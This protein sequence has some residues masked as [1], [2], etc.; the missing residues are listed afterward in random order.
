MVSRQ[1]SL[2]L[3]VMLGFSNSSGLFL[4]LWYDFSH[5]SLQSVCLSVC[6]S[7]CVCV[8]VC[9]CARM[10][11]HA[12]GHGVQKGATAPLELKLQGVVNCSLRSKPP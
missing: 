1:Q 11:M 10:H 4:V 12:R 9:V 2:D 8:C 7:V 5:T 6:L 3:S